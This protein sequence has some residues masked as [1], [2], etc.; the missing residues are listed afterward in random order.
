V[1][2][3]FGWPDLYRITPKDYAPLPETGESIIRMP[4]ITPMA[5]RLAVE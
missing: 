5:R 2:R 1:G 4:V 3:T